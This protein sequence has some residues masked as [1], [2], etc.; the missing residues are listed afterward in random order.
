MA[1]EE[2]KKCPPITYIQFV[3]I[4]LLTLFFIVYGYWNYDT[5]QAWLNIDN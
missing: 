3:F 2:N 1:E 5:F 4:V